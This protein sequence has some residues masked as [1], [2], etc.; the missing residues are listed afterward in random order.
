MKV[1]IIKTSKLRDED[2]ISIDSLVGKE[3]EILGY[4]DNYN[5]VINNDTLAKN[6][7][8]MVMGNIIL[9]GDEY[10]VVSI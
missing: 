6:E 5:L 7:V 9:Y 8:G 3:F 4:E 10:E 1:K 2:K